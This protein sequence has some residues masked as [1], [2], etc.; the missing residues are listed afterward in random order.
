MGFVLIGM[1]SVYIGHRFITKGVVN[2]IKELVSATIKFSEGS[3]DKRVHTNSRT[4]I[5]LLFESFNKMADKI[6][7][8]NE[9]LKKFGEELEEKVKGRTFELQVANMQLR[10]VHDAMIRAEKIV[11]IGQVATGVTHEI[12]TPLNA[13]S[14]NIQMLMREV[15]DKCGTD[16]CGFYKTVDLIQ[17]EVKRINDILNSFVGFA[18]FP[19]PEFV[20]HDI[21]QVI[22]DVAMFM[23]H[24]AKESGV[25]IALSLSDKIPEFRF[26]ISQ[27]KE[28]LMNLSQ[29]AINAMPYGGMLKITTCVLDNGVVVSISDSGIGIPEKNK[30]RIFSPFFSTK[31]GGLGL[32]LAIVQRIVEGHEGKINFSSNVGK[33]S[34]FE[35]IF[36]IER[37]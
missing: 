32:G 35:V 15:K 13:L 23:S 26:D 2:P 16:E 19:E 27:I 14:I 5:G 24:D 30:D 10:K 31:N 34:V 33:G 1:F 7:E 17:C 6:Q 37:G 18:K 28:V 29:N 36:P 20:Q 21:N 4:E 8:N 25:T 11:A 22:S 9:F 3:F 12:K